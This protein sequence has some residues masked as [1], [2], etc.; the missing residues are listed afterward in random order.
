V[1]YLTPGSF[2]AFI[3]TSQIQTTIFMLESSL[4][5]LEGDKKRDRFELQTHG[6][7]AGKQGI[8]PS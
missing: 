3:H 7:E 6:C 5:A 2:A 1:V 8:P 4:F